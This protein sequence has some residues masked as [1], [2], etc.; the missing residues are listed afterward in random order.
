MRDTREHR[1]EHYKNMDL[2]RF[3]EQVDAFRERL[4]NLRDNGDEVPVEDRGILEQAFQE[5]NVSMEELLVAQEEL[6]A[7]NESLIA[8]R[9]IIEQER[10]RFAD[11]FQSAP[12]GYLVTD[13]RGKI[14]D[15]N[16]AACR[17]LNIVPDYIRGQ[18]L[19]IYVV[20][21]DRKS[22]RTRLAEMQEGK[23][24]EN[25]EVRLKPIKMKP[26]FVSLTAVHVEP[27][28]GLAATIRWTLRDVSERVDMEQALR[29][30][31]Q[32]FRAIF[33]GAA[34][35][36]ALVDDR[37]HIVEANTA[38]QQM[39]GYDREGL[40]GRTLASLTFTQDMPESQ[41]LF[42]ALFAGENEGFRTEKRYVDSSGSILWTHQTASLVR[43]SGRAPRFAMVLIENITRQRALEGELSELR[44]RLV[45]SREVERTR[46]AQ[47]LHDGPLQD[48][49]GVFFQVNLLL[50][51]VKDDKLRSELNQ[52]RLGMQNIL[53]DL[54]MT[55]Y[56]LR[57]PAL[58]HYGLEKAILSYT[59]RFKSYYNFANIHLTL[60][61]DE[62]KLPDT[63]RL[64]FFRN[65][66]Q[67]LNNVIRHAHAKNIWVNFK[68][69][70]K[71]VT[72]EVRDDGSGFVMPT[73]WIDFARGSH[74]GL[75]GMIERAEALGGS[76]EIESAPGKG[77]LVRTTIPRTSPSF[78]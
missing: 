44:N 47:D 25:W 12:D 52:I 3:V 63:I 26:M 57:P 13:W 32:R 29:R 64:V 35:G 4:S 76:V 40:Q 1:T 11:L 75:L 10:Q 9:A 38:L 61:K 78:M 74:L 60:D 68:L 70:S 37:G 33:E 27:S 19:S 34:Q 56:E 7:Q 59:E 31:E 45:A 22:F 30:S 62:K 77:T 36:I 54:R 67:A 41:Q 21:D 66:Q 73:H 43:S 5:L 71:D 46:L 14:Q 65:F 18:L 58:T 16:L 20:P 49:Y 8:M 39:L 55:S 15:A 24:I 48:L 17:L 23:R 69:N 51:D 53:D 42:Q 28:D 72:L 2:G 50:P 6:H